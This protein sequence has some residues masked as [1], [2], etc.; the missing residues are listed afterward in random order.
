MALQSLAS[1]ASLAYPIAIAILVGIT[2][3]VL[4]VFHKPAFPA[5]APKATEDALPLIGSRNFFTKRWDFYKS[6]IARSATGNFSFYA[7]KWPVVGLAGHNSRKLFFES[8]QLA[9]Q[10][11]YAAL[12][13]GAPVAK[14]SAL[15]ENHSNN[16]GEYRRF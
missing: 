12:L 9:F 8:R 15:A 5:N 13:A 10:E 1:S 6:S 2:S 11:G 14:E 3:L 4:Y 7:G 16:A